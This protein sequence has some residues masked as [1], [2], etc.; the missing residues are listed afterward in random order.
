MSITSSPCK[1]CL[2][3]IMCEDPCESMID[4]AYERIKRFKKGNE[5]NRTDNYDFLYGIC[6]SMRIRPDSDIEVF[7]S[8]KGEGP[9]DKYT[10]HIWG[11]TIMLISRYS[12]DELSM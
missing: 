3:D 12:D 10:L 9:V 6:K 2:I 1:N 5:Y 7:L 4:K 8:T 11:R